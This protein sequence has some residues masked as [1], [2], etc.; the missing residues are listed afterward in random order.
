MPLSD[1]WSIP[2]RSLYSKNIPNL[3]M[4]G[5]NISI[6]H[7]AMGSARVMATCAIEGQAV[8]HAAALCLRHDETPRELCASHISEL[9]QGLLK[10]DCYIIDLKNEDP[11]DLARTASASTSSQAAL[12]LPETGTPCSLKTAVAHLIPVSG[13]KL[14]WVEFLLKAEQ[15]ASATLRV[16]SAP[17]LNTQPGAGE[18]LCAV[19]AAVPV[20]EP[21]WVRFELNIDQKVDCFLWLELTEAPLISRYHSEGSNLPTVR[22]AAPVSRLWR[23]QKGFSAMRIFPA[24]YPYGSENVLS[25]VAR[26]E[27]WTNLWIS[28]PAAALPQWLELDLGTEKC[29]NT[30]NVTFDTDLDTNVYLP[31]PWGV[32]GIGAMPTCVKDYDILALVDGQWT[33]VCSQRGNYHRHNIHRFPAVTT[34]KLRIQVLATNGDPS[35][36]IF[37]VRCYNE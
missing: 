13:G 22:L 34:Q 3:M 1:I 23:N 19:S 15:S 28:N 16:W 17:R 8:G 26:P 31:K 12:T 30:V 11:A 37:E 10:Q 32:F 29:V 14:Q 35:A 25:G 24:S 2:F 18:L 6:T 5:R 9:Q 20:D 4:A 27:K 36:R 21:R 33:T 7:A